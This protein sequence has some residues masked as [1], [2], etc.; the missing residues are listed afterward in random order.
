MM[1]EKASTKSADCSLVEKARD[2]DLIAKE[3]S[4]SAT[5]EIKLFPAID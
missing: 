4:R 2:P 1:S 3:V 5:K